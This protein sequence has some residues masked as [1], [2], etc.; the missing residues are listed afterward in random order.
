MTYEVIGFKPE[1]LKELSEQESMK[2]LSEYMA[3]D[4]AEKLAEAGNS[5]TIKANDRVVFCGGAIVYWEGR[6]EVWSIIDRDCREHFY[7]IHKA[8][9]R[10]LE[11]LSMRRVE[12]TVDH[13]FEQGHRWV[14]TLGF[15]LETPCMKGYRPNG[16]DCA[17]YV[18]FDNG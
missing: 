10:F 1:H 4:C 7:A 16:G 12:A 5:Y 11:V 2:Y 3:S 15:Q 13:G 8:T 6:A 17:M 9:K 14:R 18:R